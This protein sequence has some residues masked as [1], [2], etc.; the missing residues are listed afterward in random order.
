MRTFSII[1][2][3]FLSLSGFAQLQIAVENTG[4]SLFF[5]NLKEAIE[6]AESGATIYLPGGVFET[7]NATISKKLRIV[8]LGH[9][10]NGNPNGAYTRIVG[11]LVIA[12]GAS[13]SKLEGMHIAGDVAVGT[14]FDVN[15]ITNLT[16]SRCNF[17]DQTLLLSQGALPTDGIIITECVLDAVDGGTA[18]NVLILKSIAKKTFINLTSLVTFKNNIFLYD[19]AAVTFQDVKNATF[20]NNIFLCAFT[21]ITNST[22]SNNIFQQGYD[23][24]FAASGNN[25]ASNHTGIA[26]ADIFVNVPDK[27]FSYDHNYQLKGTSVGVG[28]GEDSKD[29][30]IYGTNI[31]FKT[32]GVPDVPHINSVN[33][34]S[35]TDSQGRL[36]ISIKVSAQGN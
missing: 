14:A 8:G 20:E 13:D 9:N 16:F 35:S 21:G 24:G 28:A 27:T 22:L 29:I 19:Q 11:N 17:V 31:P 23:Y 30:G 26:L 32:S 1:L 25:E 18:T 5:S 12:D 34:D 36:S 2:L 3:L 33:I 7:E 4:G 6:N 15:A 10:P